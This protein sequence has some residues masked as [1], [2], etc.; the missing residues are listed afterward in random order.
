MPPQAYFNRVSNL[1]CHNLCQSTYIPPAVTN[2]LG[3]GLKFCIADRPPPN[4]LSNSFSR[5]RDDVRTRYHISSSGGSDDNSDNPSYDPKLYVK[6][7][8]W[9]PDP[10]SR[11]IEAAM[12]MF[13]TSINKEIASHAPGFQP[14]LLK[15]ELRLL[16]SI[17]NN[18][19]LVILQ[20]DKN[21]GPAVWERSEY[22]KQTLNE[23]LLDPTTYQQLTHGAAMTRVDYTK[24]LVNSHYNKFWYDLKDFERS[25]FTRTMEQSNFRILQYYGMPK[26]HKETLKTRP[27]VSCTNS[28]PQVLSKHLDFH[29]KSVV[30]QCPGY[31]RDSRQFI[32]DINELGTLPPGARLFTADATSM[33]TNIDTSHAIQIIG[34]WLRM[35]NRKL[36][37]SFPPIDFILKGLKIV[38]T[39]NV[40]QFGD[41]YW[42]Q[43]NGTAMGTS[44]ACMYATIYYSYHE[45]TRLLNPTVD[46]GIIF[47]R[48][49]IDDAFLIHLPS[50]GSYD[51]LVEDIN[52]FGDKN[53]RLEW[54]ATPMATENVIFLDLN[55][56]IQPNGSVKTKTYVKP[57][58]LHLY[59]PAHSA[60]PPGLLKSLV[61][62]QL[63][64][65]WTQCTN[66]T[67][68]TDITNDFYGHL[69]KR[70][71]GQ[72]MLNQHF[73]DVAS[74]LDRQGIR[75]PSAD[76]NSKRNEEE[77]IRFHL[78]Y[79][80]YQISRRSIRV[81][82]DKHCSA[83]LNTATSKKGNNPLGINKLTIAYSR[84]PNIR[85]KLCSSKLQ[86]CPGQNV[87]DALNSIS[88]HDSAS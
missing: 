46:N 49:L 9:C 83:I 70:G 30:K 38:M 31:L 21:L 45:E 27:V 73:Q 68:F 42:I 52:D 87:S 44:V 65:F 50:P 69:L 6:N 26:V 22:I 10:A 72:E 54:K 48:R 51:K 67:D 40:F 11:D 41:T 1:T 5:L 33:Y 4:K 39:N 34:K 43:L 28:I 64:R 85:D 82:F 12:D 88:Q 14:N 74:K 55:I 57:M 19:D 18:Q 56:A 7:L 77:D 76:I 86:N 20:T 75:T 71:Y 61:H 24:H 80:P 13:E 79:H 53:F 29:L 25:Y 37:D 60:H 62:G 16:Q 81:C 23:H 35:P 78:Q 17:R 66:V 47:Y 63:Q 32:D 3:L 15:Y 59:I 58:N 2:L 8:E 84:A 36:P